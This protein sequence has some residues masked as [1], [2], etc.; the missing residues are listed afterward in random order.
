[1]TGPESTPPAPEELPAVTP[2]S[3]G[4]FVQLFVVPALIVVGIMSVWYLFG[5][6]ASGDGSVDEYIAIIKSDRGDRWKAALDLSQLLRE[7]SPYAKDRALALTLTDELNKALDAGESADQQ[8]VE[9]LVGAV[10]SFQLPIGSPM[11]RQAAR[12]DHKRSIRRAA[13]IALGNLA[14]RCGDLNDPNVVPELIGYLGDDDGELRKISVIVLGKLNDNRAIG[15]LKTILGDARPEVRHLAA[16]SLAELGDAS[17]LVVIPEML[18]EASLRKLFVIQTESGENVVDE[19]MVGGTLHNA[20]VSLRDLVAK[21]PA[22]DFT[23]VIAPLE[24]LATDPNPRV[25]TE[26]KEVLLKIKSA[27][28]QPEKQIKS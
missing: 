15:P 14:V 20:M 9:Y 28:S 18:D 10:G 26:A 24:E 7:D 8:Y 4:F 12:P 11:L 25:A 1:M 2:P 27:A 6:I 17:G 13:L 21:R 16:R 5:K 19:Q 3:A 22:T 23:P